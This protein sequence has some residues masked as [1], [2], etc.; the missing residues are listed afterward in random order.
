MSVPPVLS[1]P[2]GDTSCAVHMW[3]GRD[4]LL[5]CRNTQNDGPFTLSSGVVTPVE[6]ASP[7]HPSHNIQCNN[8]ADMDV[9]ISAPSGSMLQCSR[10]SVVMAPHAALVH[11]HLLLLTVVLPWRLKSLNI[12]RD[13]PLHHR[14]TNSY[15]SSAPRPDRSACRTISH[16]YSSA[17]DLSQPALQIIVDANISVPSL[18]CIRSEPKVTTEDIRFKIIDSRHYPDIQDHILSA[19]HGSNISPKSLSCMLLNVGIKYDPNEGYF[20]VAG[21]A[22]CRP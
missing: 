20:E 11:P 18:H 21:S 3:L 14:S 1:P 16:N 7:V 17:A 6:L 12:V 9:D 19:I 22:A 4:W 13:I 5:F 2:Y 15:A 10:V 8:D